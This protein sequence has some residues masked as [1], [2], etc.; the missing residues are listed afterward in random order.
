MDESLLMSKEEIKEAAKNMQP[1]VL[2]IY[3]SQTADKEIQHKKRFRKTI[4]G[5]VYEGELIL[6]ADKKNYNSATDKYE[7]YYRGEMTAVE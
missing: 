7:L 2:E 6:V 1:V 4:E 3:R 5:V